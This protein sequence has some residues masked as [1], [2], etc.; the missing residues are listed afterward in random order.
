M[1]FI[2]LSSVDSTNSFLKQWVQQSKKHTAIG[3]WAEHQ[4]HG[5]GR[6]GTQWHATK[7]LNLTGSVYLGNISIDIQT[8][9]EINKR[10]CLAV[11]E[12]LLAH[13]IPELQ[14]KWP[15]DILAKG[16]K[17]GGILVEPILRGAK[18]TDVVI[19]CGI[20]VNEK[21]LPN[22]PCATS[23]SA[24]TGKS[25]DIESLFE[26][27]AANIEHTVRGKHTDDKRYLTTLYGLG[28]PC[29]FERKDSIPFTATIVDV[30]K[31]G[32]LVVEHKNGEREIFEE[33]ALVFTAFSRCR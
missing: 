25:Y 4:T 17:I 16:K 13:K 29:S 10:V 9:F 7:G 20:N 28:E 3:V 24:I 23:L 8:L 15:N 27:L 18:V 22:L 32:K 30:A 11:I 33:K 14:I 31:D 6:M 12:T 5:K 2:K 1:L 19:G 21:A 26:A